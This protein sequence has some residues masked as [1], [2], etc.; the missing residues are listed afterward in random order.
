MRAEQGLH[1]GHTEMA[2]KAYDVLS[3]RELE[4]RTHVHLLGQRRFVGLR[5]DGHP[6]RLAADRDLRGIFQDRPEALRCA[7]LA[8][9]THIARWHFDAVMPGHGQCAPQRGVLRMVQQRNP[10]PQQQ[11]WVLQAIP[12]RRL[13][14]RFNDPRIHHE[15]PNHDTFGN[16]HGF[17]RPGQER[18]QQC[19]TLLIPDQGALSW[20]GWSGHRQEPHGVGGPRRPSAVR[21][22]A[23]RRLCRALLSHGARGLSRGAGDLFHRFGRKLSLHGQSFKTQ[24]GFQ[25]IAF[26]RGQLHMHHHDFLSLW[27]LFPASLRRL[28][29][30]LLP[31][32]LRRHSS[33]QLSCMYNLLPLPCQNLLPRLDPLEGVPLS[34]AF[35]WLAAPELLSPLFCQHPGPALIL[36]AHRIETDAIQVSFEIGPIRIRAQ[37]CET[38][39]TG[40][41]TMRGPVLG[42]DRRKNAMQALACA[43]LP[44]QT[45]GPGRTWATVERQN[46]HAQPGVRRSCIIC[47]PIVQVKGPP[48]RWPHA[49]QVHLN[50]PMLHRRQELLKLSRHKIGIHQVAGRIVLHGFPPYLQLSQGWGV[51]EGECGARRVGQGRGDH[52]A[53]PLAPQGRLRCRR[54]T[55]HWLVED[56]SSPSAV[57]RRRQDV[58]GSRTMSKALPTQGQG[59]HRDGRWW[60]SWRQDVC[61]TL[62]AGCL[63]IEVSLW[64]SVSLREARA[65]SVV[66]GKIPPTAWQSSVR[67]G[68]G[69]TSVVSARPRAASRGYE[70]SCPRQQGWLRLS[71]LLCQ[72][73]RLLPSRV[74]SWDLLRA[75]HATPRC[76]ARPPQTHD[77]LFSRYRLCT[78]LGT[79]LPASAPGMVRRRPAARAYLQPPAAAHRAGPWTYGPLNQDSAT[80]RPAGTHRGWGGPRPQGTSAQGAAAASRTEA[81]PAPTVGPLLPHARLLPGCSRRH[82]AVRR[83]RKE[84]RPSSPR[85]PRARPAPPAPCAAPRLTA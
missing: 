39:R 54:S 23:C 45:P 22:L 71:F 9:P 7:H 63:T 11:L 68:S 3:R 38:H 14:R 43:G 48:D 69:H 15:I 16:R 27:P 34:C 58:Q 40:D 84:G 35:W 4:V 83:S 13:C 82:A 50:V 41:E 61:A 80:D 46:I 62:P 49:H 33:P 65:R 60:M 76:A 42:T 85:A 6:I 32:P 57:A 78:V 37:A 75:P 1:F 17:M 24:G 59:A 44:D 56:G 18:L 47:P 53:A 20:V 28:L 12:G 55:S 8:D 73:G 66:G 70:R 2:A 21:Q 77:R 79:R 51:R 19:G 25:G 36:P 52:G 5:Q 31:P 30:H 74:R 81:R 67:D 64:G 72:R 26:L 29:S 10:L